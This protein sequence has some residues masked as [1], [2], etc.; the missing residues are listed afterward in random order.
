MLFMQ[1]YLIIYCLFIL[2]KFVLTISVVLPVFCNSEMFNI[3]NFTIL[4]YHEIRGIR[5]M[6][7]LYV[8]LI[9]RFILVLDIIQI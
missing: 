1:L 8:I 3:G 9:N 4:I 6:R 7:I 2:F 5:L